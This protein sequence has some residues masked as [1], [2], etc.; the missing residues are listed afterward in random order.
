MG[1]F[2]VSGRK[3]SKIQRVYDRQRRGIIPIP[4]PQGRSRKRRSGGSQQA[5]RWGNA[6][7]SL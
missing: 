1:V 2:Y 5:S 3:L 7:I 4:I 6:C